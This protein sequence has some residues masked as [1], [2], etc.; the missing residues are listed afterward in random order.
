MG[1]THIQL[2]LIIL[3]S[4]ILVL[5]KWG[6]LP[7]LMGNLSFGVEEVEEVRSLLTYEDVFKFDYALIILT[8]YC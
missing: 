5:T 6:F 1:Y 4:K 7:A 2:L 3:I 8:S